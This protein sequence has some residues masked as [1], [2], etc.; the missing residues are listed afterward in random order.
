[1]LGTISGLHLTSRR[2]GATETADGATTDTLAGARGVAAGV[3]LNQTLDVNDDVLS[4]NR[5]NKYLRTRL[6]F[7]AYLFPLLRTIRVHCNATAKTQLH[8]VRNTSY[9]E[10]TF[11]DL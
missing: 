9:I 3:S 6:Y 1:M 7:Y 8:N 2:T 4:C 11:G 10:L 5:N